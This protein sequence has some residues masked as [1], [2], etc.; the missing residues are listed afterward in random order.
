M[1]MTLAAILVFAASALWAQDVV[2]LWESDRAV[3]ETELAGG[4]RKGF[5]L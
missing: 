5:V 2:P 4:V 3:L 1:K